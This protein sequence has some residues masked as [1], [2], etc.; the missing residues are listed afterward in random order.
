MQSTV[1]RHSIG[2]VTQHYSVALLWRSDV[3]LFQE[4]CDSFCYA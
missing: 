3:D 4:F 1:H 2:G